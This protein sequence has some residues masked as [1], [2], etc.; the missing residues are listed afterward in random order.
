MDE[1]Y[2]N[3]KLFCQLTQSRFQ[4]LKSRLWGVSSDLINKPCFV[5]AKMNKTEKTFSSIGCRINDKMYHTYKDCLMTAWWLPDDC[6][7]TAWW[8]PD[9]CLTTASW[10]PDNCLMTSYVTLTWPLNHSKDNFSHNLRQRQENYGPMR[11]CSWRAA[12]KDR[13]HCCYALKMYELY[14]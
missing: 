14:Q 12:K 9:D 8:L 3:K 11:M 5:Q 13:N 10:T 6:L 2:Q 4:T 7:T 1:G